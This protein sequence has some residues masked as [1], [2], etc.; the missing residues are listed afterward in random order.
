M[1]AT[2]P[3]PVPAAVASAAVS[4]QSV[5]VKLAAVASTV[6][7]ALTAATH[8]LPTFESAILTGIGPIVFLVERYWADIRKVL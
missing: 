8:G 2:T 7:G 4:V 3:T 6:A 5:L 1:P